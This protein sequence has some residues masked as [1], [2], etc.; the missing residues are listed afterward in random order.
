MVTQPIHL[1]KVYD[2]GGK[3]WD[4]YT[5]LTEPAEHDHQLYECLGLSDNCD[6]PSGFSQFGEAVDG[7]H[8][9]RVVTLK[10]LPEPVVRHAIGRLLT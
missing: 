8:L 10:Q 1:F 6:S 2:N 7:E 4:R 5:F 9:G 3:T